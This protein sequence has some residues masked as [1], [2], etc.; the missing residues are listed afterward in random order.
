MSGP[1]AATGVDA[2]DL[3][4]TPEV[5]MTVGGFQRHP[6][7]SVSPGTLSTHAHRPAAAMPAPTD[8][9]AER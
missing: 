6:G 8:R 3:I 9:T 2:G 1:R 7:G 4:D 5:G